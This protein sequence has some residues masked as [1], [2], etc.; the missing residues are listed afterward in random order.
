[1]YRNNPEELSIA[2]DRYF[3]RLTEVQGRALDYIA[4]S[5]SARRVL[6]TSSTGTGKTRMAMEYISRFDGYMNNHIP[7]VI[8]PKATKE[9]WIEAFGKSGRKAVDAIKIGM[10]TN[11]EIADALVTTPQCLGRWMTTN[12]NSRKQEVKDRNQIFASRFGMVLYDEVH[13]A[14]RNSQAL[15]ALRRFMPYCEATYAM[16]ATPDWNNPENIYELCKVIY[17][18]INHMPEDMFR[19][20][21][22]IQEPFVRDAKPYDRKRGLRVFMNHRGDLVCEDF[23]VTG[24]KSPDSVDEYLSYMP[25][26][27]SVRNKLLPYEHRRVEIQLPHKQMAQYDNMLDYKTIETRTGDYVADYPIVARIRMRQICLAEVESVDL[28]AVLRK[29]VEAGKKPPKS[30]PDIRFT[31]GGASPKA[32]WIAHAAEV[33]KRRVI[34]WTDSAQFAELLE[35][36]IPNLMA[37][38]GKMSPKKRKGAVDW[39]H[40]TSNAFLCIVCAAGGTGLDGLQRTCNTQIWANRSEPLWGAQERQCLGRLNRTGSPFGKVYNYELVAKGTMED[41]K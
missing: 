24:W 40:R 34:V 39:F 11:M 15:D 23:K 7:I 22:C 41:V 2:D 28:E 35:R 5:G 3:E 26:V 37:Y 29:L 36:R 18:N 31:E 19:Q 17:P 33:S 27:V 10:D 32:D 6:N 21:F 38:T 8:C 30:L 16:S 25:C 1:M 9:Q 4:A 14:S 13:S 20:R 12:S